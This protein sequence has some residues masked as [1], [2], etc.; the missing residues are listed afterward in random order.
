MFSMPDWSTVLLGPVGSRLASMSTSLAM[1][2]KLTRLSL[3]SE[4]AKLI[5]R[6]DLH[7][8]NQ[9]IMGTSFEKVW[10]QE[11]ARLDELLGKWECE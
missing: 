3:V 7:D 9:S 11:K 1:L 10:L 2:S 4:E 6:A 5:K 8:N